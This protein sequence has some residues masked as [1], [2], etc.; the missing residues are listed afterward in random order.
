MDWLVQQARQLG[1]CIVM[2]GRSAWP[3]TRQYRPIFLSLC[4]L[5]MFHTVSGVST[6]C[7]PFMTGFICPNSTTI[8]D[9][10]TDPC[11]CTLGCACAPGGA[12]YSASL[13]CTCVSTMASVGA[14]V[15]LEADAATV[16]SSFS[17]SI[18]SLGAE[19]PVMLTDT[20]SN[21]SA[22]PNSSNPYAFLAPVLFSQ[23]APQHRVFL[24]FAFGR[25]AL[26]RCALFSSSF[27]SRRHA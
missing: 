22:S 20:V 24:A 8:A 5:H 6:S 25:L 21:S 17:V 10:V 1:R 2:F 12:L 27:R 19:P 11:V 26:H 23:S 14:F 18:S 7:S 3:A 16:N 4:I 9:L 15:W 13:S